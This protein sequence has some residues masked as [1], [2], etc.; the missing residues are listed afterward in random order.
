MAVP[1]RESAKVRFGKFSITVPGSKRQ[2]TVLGVAL[3]VGGCLGFLPI[4]GFWMLPLG[5]LI[6]S[7]EYHAV[8]RFRRKLEV[9]YG[10]RRKK[11]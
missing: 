6:L 3:C 8:R 11:R 5:L 9:W 4:L 2:R 7:L 1:P 10:R